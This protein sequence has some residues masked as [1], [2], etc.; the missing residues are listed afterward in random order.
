MKPQPPSSLSQPDK[1]K[2]AAREV[3]T[4][5]D[6]ERFKERLAKLVRHKPAPEK[7]DIRK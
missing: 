7:P 3:E 5:D 1:F 4:H 6:P 2:D